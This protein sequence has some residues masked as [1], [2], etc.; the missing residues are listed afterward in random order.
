M[1][2]ILLLT[3]LATAAV[4]AMGQGQ[5]NFQNNTLT[6]YYLNTTSTGGSRVKSPTSTPMDVALFYYD[7][8]TGSLGGASNTA[9]YVFATAVPMSGTSAGQIVGAAALPLSTTTAGDLIS[10]FTVEWDGTAAGGLNAYQTGLARSGTAA[11]W[12]GGG[13][14]FGYTGIILG[15]SGTGILTTGAPAPGTVVFQN[16]AGLIGTVG[17]VTDILPVPEPASFALAG[18]GAAAMLI[19]RRRK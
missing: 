14:Y 10:L 5:I 3:T 17:G 9:N 2:K 16:S 1:K 15:Q 8:T 6:A 7:I 4:S 18:L 13:S 12:I 19:F 11:T